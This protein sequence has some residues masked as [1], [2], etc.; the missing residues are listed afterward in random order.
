[1]CLDQKVQETDFFTETKN[2]LGVEH[3]LGPKEWVVKLM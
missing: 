3:T 2:I 1:M